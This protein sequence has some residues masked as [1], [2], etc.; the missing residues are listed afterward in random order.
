MFPHVH[1]WGPPANTTGPLHEELH[2]EKKLPNVRELALYIF[3]AA[4]AFSSLSRSSQLVPSRSQ[5]LCRREAVSQNLHR[6]VIY[7]L[8]LLLFDSRSTAELP[9]TAEMNWK[10]PLQPLM[11]R[12]AVWQENQ[13]S[14]PHSLRG[15][16]ETISF[17]LSEFL[18]HLL[19]SLTFTWREIS[20]V[21]SCHLC[22][23]M[24]WKVYPVF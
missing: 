8:S 22:A 11:N 6:P 19:I 9:Q 16:W 20:F 2:R 3:N 1:T 18:L 24:M 13:M 4:K 17:S 15:Y 7:S 21:I 23:G 14:F 12:L 10:P 5:Q